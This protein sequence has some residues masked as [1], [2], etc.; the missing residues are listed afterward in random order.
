MLKVKNNISY[1]TLIHVHT[2]TEEAK[3]MKSIYFMKNR[4]YYMRKQ[5]NTIHQFV[6]GNLNTKLGKEAYLQETT[7]NGCEPA[8]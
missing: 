4:N 5:I 1:I 8:I 3:V 6:M 2:T 7:G